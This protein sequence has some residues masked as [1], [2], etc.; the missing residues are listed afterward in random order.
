MGT[1]S[2]MGSAPAL[3]IHRALTGQTDLVNHGLL[4]VLKH[5]LLNS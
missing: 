1:W 2:A 4:V 3:T 5:L